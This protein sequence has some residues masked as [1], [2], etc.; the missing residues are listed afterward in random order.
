MVRGFQYITYRIFP[1]EQDWSHDRVK[2]IGGILAKDNRF[3]SVEFDRNSFQSWFCVYEN[4]TA[5]E[6]TQ[7]NFQWKQRLFATLLVVSGNSSEWDLLTHHS[8]FDVHVPAVSESYR[9]RCF[10]RPCFRKKQRRKNF[11]EMAEGATTLKGLRAQMGKK[12][13]ELDFIFAEVVSQ[14]VVSLCNVVLQ[15]PPLTGWF[16]RRPAFL[17]SNVSSVSAYLLTMDAEKPAI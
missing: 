9:L 15:L 12:L 17:A 16:E 13:L 1:F 6:P 2:L 3:I 4:K 10:A 8:I 14:D 7:V 11:R 5:V